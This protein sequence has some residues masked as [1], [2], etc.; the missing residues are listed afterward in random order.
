MSQEKRQRQDDLFAEG[1]DREVDAGSIRYDGPIRAAKRNRPRKSRGPYLAAALLAGAVVVLL[2]V[3]L[4]L[5]GEPDNPPVPPPTA[6]LRTNPSA[7]TPEEP[8]LPETA[9]VSDTAT[10]PP[11]AG[12]APSPVTPAPEPNEAPTI[13]ADTPPP[14]PAPRTVPATPPAAEPASAATVG[15]L[16]R[17]GDLGG[18]CRLGRTLAE[19]AAK[20]GAF[21]IQVLSASDPDS[22]RQA[23]TRVRDRRLVVVNVPSPGGT[24]YRLLWGFHPSRDAAR[25]AA[26][27]CPDYFPRSS[28]WPYTPTVATVLA[29]IQR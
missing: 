11:T 29:P 1:E 21:T 12:R 20:G 2:G 13:A 14:A 28:G 22:V 3:A 9:A 23:F 25:S 4:W 5:R 26:A 10:T 27:S 19:E 7:P 15:D 24:H 6:S 17:S 16:V 8:T 18:A